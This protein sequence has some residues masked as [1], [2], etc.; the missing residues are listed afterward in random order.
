MRKE[1]T[2]SD[3]TSIY[4]SLILLLDVTIH[5]SFRAKKRLE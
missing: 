3:Y 4:T 1:Y 5:I 2:H